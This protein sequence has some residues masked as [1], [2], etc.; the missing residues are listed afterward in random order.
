MRKMMFTLLSLCLWTVTARAVTEDDFLK[1]VGLPPK[2]KP[3]MRQ[4]GEALPPL[5]L[6]ATPL[7]RSEKKRPPSPSTFIGKVV[8]GGY[9]DYT[10][11]SGQ[12]TRV[13]D[14]NMV[15]ADCQSL[16]RMATRHLN[17][18][19]K[20]ETVSLDSFTAMPGEIPVLY[21]S[22][23]RSLNFTKKE[24]ETLR[25]YLLAG[26]TV[27]FDSIVGSPFFYKSA[28]SEL[29]QILP[30]AQIRRLPDD[31]PVFHIVNDAVTLK[32]KSKEETA[33]VLDGVY[34]GSR[35]AAFVSPYGLG[36]GW[37]NTAPT[38]IQ[39]A[40]FYDPASSAQLGLNLLAYAVGYFRVG[41]AHAQAQTYSESD[42]SPDKDPVVFAQVQTSG[43]W[44]TEPGGANN[45]LRFMRKNLTVQ[46]N[47]KIQTIRLDRDPLADYPFLYLSG[48][49]DFTLHPS[50]RAALKRYLD[51]G[52]FLL[53]DN[54]LGMREFRMAVYREIGKLY[55]ESR[56]KRLEGDHPLFT[57]GP[58]KL[59]AVTYTLAARAK[60]PTLTA[61][62]IEA[63]EIDG[64][65][66]ILFS[67][68]DLAAG[69]QG[70]DHPLAY[71]YDTGDALRLGADLITYCLT[72]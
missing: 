7:R 71:G 37:D 39:Q 28:L 58:F 61:P 68:F 55:P 46:A 16:L 34:I 21:F 3:Q 67:P 27:W 36:A 53:I 54:A 9:L 17:M 30:E 25:H 56:F 32:T 40:D 19:Y 69:W 35:V 14:W 63:V 45:L 33:P 11:E 24:R 1:P 38:L 41:L 15:P 10:W 44:N 6:P 5:P 72:H 13:F 66:H 70:D 4:G 23:G 59:T 64:A 18:E 60:Y 26:G 12:V 31:H 8:W 52:G 43:V 51:D 57:T 20:V 2:G 62:F 22:G 65:P 50:E 29:A 48:I 49:T 42:L 47:Y